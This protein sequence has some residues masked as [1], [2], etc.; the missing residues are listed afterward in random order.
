M[1]QENTNADGHVGRIRRGRGDRRRPRRTGMTTS[2][3]EVADHAAHGSEHA[4]P[5]AHF[6]DANFQRVLE[7]VRGATARFHDLDTAKA[8]G[9]EL[10]WVNGAGTRIIAGLRRQSQPGGGAMGYHYFNKKLM[11]DDKV[12][13]LK[14]E[15]LVYATGDDGELELVAVEWVARGPNSNPP[16]PAE[17]PTV[18]GHADAHP[19]PSRGL[20]HHAR[21]VVEAEPRRNVC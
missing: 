15:V 2:A 20:P 14:P 11:A 9:Y 19:R 17:P 6:G 18:L 16:G 12:N 10:G 4:S 7:Q 8:A 13:L 21:L 3:A 5:N 1:Q